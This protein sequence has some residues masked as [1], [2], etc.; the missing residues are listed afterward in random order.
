[1]FQLRAI[2]WLIGRI[3]DKLN[4]LHEGPCDIRAAGNERRPMAPFREY[5]AMTD[6]QC[7]GI[8]SRAIKIKTELSLLETTELHN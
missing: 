5:K 7:A 1:M 6:P 3:Y 2:H 8:P 4:V